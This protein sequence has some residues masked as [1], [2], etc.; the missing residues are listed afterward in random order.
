MTLHIVL[1]F[2]DFSEYSAKVAD[3]LK[4]VGIK[5]VFF[6]NTAVIRS[7][8]EQ[9]LVKELAKYHEVG[10]HSHNHLDLTQLPLEEALRDL[11]KS[12]EVLHE[13]TGKYVKSF[14]YPYGSYSNEVVEAVR[15][16]GFT[17]ARTVE[18]KPPLTEIKDPLKLPVL[19]HDHSLTNKR[20]VYEILRNLLVGKLY[21]AKLYQIMLIEKQ[22]G[23]LETTKSLLNFIA[24][25]HLPKDILIIF[26]FHP[27]MIERVKGWE[28]FEE[29]ALL[30]KGVGRI[31]TLE[32]AYCKFYAK[33]WLEEI[34]GKHA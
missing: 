33:A 32:N 12:R 28:V 3:V 4:S 17:M 7:I 14:A 9:D 11:L 23:F 21:T 16:A 29:V 13:L 31:I 24:S 22:R 25:M 8:E 19:Y 1:T 27:W 10:S 2:D 5:G 18:V 34:K 15:R 30:A 26:L 6:I 20:L